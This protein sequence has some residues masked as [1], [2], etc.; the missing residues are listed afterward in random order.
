M[1]D[2][3]NDDNNSGVI[4]AWTILTPKLVVSGLESNLD[5]S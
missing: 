5:K 4:L 2:G 1:V 3:I